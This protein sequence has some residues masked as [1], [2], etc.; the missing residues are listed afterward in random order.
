MWAIFNSYVSLP[1]GNNNDSEISL[2]MVDSLVIF[3]ISHHP[4]L[5]EERMKKLSS[6]RWAGDIP[7]II[8][9]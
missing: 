9:S 4:F 7:D 2:A 3:V 5:P 8:L 6:S 1:K